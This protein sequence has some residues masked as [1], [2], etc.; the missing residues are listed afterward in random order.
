[1]KRRVPGLSDVF[2]AVRFGIIWSKAQ[3]LASRHAYE[4]AL[5][6]LKLAY[7]A[8]DSTIPS[9]NVSVETN[10]LASTVQAGLGDVSNALISI[11]LALKQLEEPNPLHNGDTRDYLKL[12][13]KWMLD[14]GGSTL[15]IDVKE[16]SD[17]IAR[18][19][20]G[21]NL[22]KVRYDV[23]KNFPMPHLAD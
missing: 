10:I 22:R 2:T 16:E 6:E 12:Y 21:V 19:V 4:E 8:M 3:S 14:Y 9:Q 7:K 11:R 20:S 13:C 15:G 18:Q 5:D 17:S 1:M 23:R